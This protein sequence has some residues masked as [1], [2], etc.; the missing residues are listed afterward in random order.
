MIGQARQTDSEAKTEQT[1]SLIGRCYDMR[2]RLRKE[3]K[4]KF[5]D[6]EKDGF[7]E[8]HDYRERDTNCTARNR[9]RQTSDVLG[10]V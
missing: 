4:D 1:D 2:R 10:A 6:I 7:K 3:E 8:A 9:R 5:I